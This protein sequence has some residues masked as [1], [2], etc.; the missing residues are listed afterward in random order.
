MS[1]DVMAWVWKHSPEKGSALLLLLAIAD[2]AND[3]GVA[4]PSIAR[5]ADKTRLSERNTQY[6]INKLVESGAIQIQKGAGPHGCHLFRVQGLQGEIWGSEGVQPSV[7]RGATAIAPEPSRTI[8]EPSRGR[9]ASRAT[10]IPPDF[11]V[12]PRVQAWAQQKGFAA[13]LPQHL[14]HFLSYA[15]A[16]GARY[17]DWDEAF[18]NAVRADWGQI[19]RNAGVKPTVQAPAC[20]FRGLPY[21]ESREP[22]GM[23]NARPD[24]DYGNQPLCV[25]HRNQVADDQR[26]LRTAMP[27]SARAV[28]SGMGHLKK[29]PA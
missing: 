4:Y 27:Q 24:P 26:P 29:T 17:V 6:L 11:K 15:K 18:M 5:L 23:P 7:E 25:H 2:H 21:V 16:K 12:S 19:R 20:N 3:A 14:E 22:C 9:R 10:P 13:L 8:K 28:L 1:V